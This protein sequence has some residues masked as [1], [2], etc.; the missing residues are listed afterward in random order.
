[1]GDQAMNPDQPHVQPYRPTD[2]THKAINSA[3]T[4]SHCAYTCKFDFAKLE[5]SLLS[6]FG[7]PPPSLFLLCFHLHFVRRSTN[8]FNGQ[9]CEAVPQWSLI[10]LASFKAL[11]S[12]SS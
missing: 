12:I 10:V 1:M 9:Y 11:K 4:S 3:I 8:N 5:C 2:S 7:T 6:R